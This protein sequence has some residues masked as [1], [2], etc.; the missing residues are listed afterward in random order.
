MP[1]LVP[2]L[3]SILSISCGS[4]PESSR[5]RA[6]PPPGVLEQLEVV[7]AGNPGRAAIKAGLDV[8]LP[9]YGAP[10][11]EEYYNRAGSA[12]LLLTKSEPEISEMA[13]VSCMIKAKYPNVDFPSAAA[14]AL[15]EVKTNG[16]R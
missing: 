9:M 3:V 5:S 2:F 15:V 16:C 14:L 1:R 7:F 4:A 6:T 13:I 8:A 12:L 10:V 11:S